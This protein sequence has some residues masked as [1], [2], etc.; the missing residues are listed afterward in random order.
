[1]ERRKLLFTGAAALSIGARRILG[2]NDRVRV[3]L[4]G[5]G[6]RGNAHLGS[7]LQIPGSQLAAICDVNQAAR[8]RANARITKA[9]QDKAV[10]FSDMRKL[11]DSKDIDAVSMATPNHWHALGAI[12]A[13][14]AGKDTYCEKPA[15]H[16]PFESKQMIAAARKYG[17]M[18]QIGSQSRSTPHCIEAI[19]AL[20]DGIIGKV[21]MS[22]GLCFKRRK[23][24]G[25]KPDAPVPPGLDWDMFLGPAPMRPFNELRFAYNWHWFWDTGN[26]DLGNQGVHQM[27]IAR[28]GMGVANDHAGMKSVV[29]TGGKY[30]Y[31]DDQETPNTQLAT[32]D[33]GD[34]EIVFEVRGVL[35][36]GEGTLGAGPKATN[37]VG[38]LFYGVDGWMEL[39]GSGYRVY[40]GE[41]NEVVKNVKAER[42]QDGTV[43]HMENF[44]AAVK[45][46]NYKSLNAEIEIGGAAADLCH[47]A[48]ISY[49]AGKR[50]KWDE[51]KHTFDDVAANKMLTREYRKPYVVPVKL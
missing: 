50:L 38:N 9:G 40:K 45:S 48:N 51:T 26:G 35:T 22:K 18:C 1:M 36:G 41:N 16:N 30:A 15:S 11:F 4:I 8:E 47:F 10:E 49:R 46:R 28:W 13:M 17:R 7:Y 6:G 25:K 43:R 44:L 29:S 23:S 3:G 14:A 39:D 19:A 5:L 20:K 24:I 2:A 42:G 12:W 27:D 32:F 34:R 37:A 33:Y 31:D 21:Y